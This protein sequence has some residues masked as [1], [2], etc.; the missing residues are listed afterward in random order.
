MAKKPHRTDKQPEGEPA[1]THAD[2]KTPLE[3]NV[4]R[5]WS[6]HTTMIISAITLLVVA[7]YTYYAGSQLSVMHGQLRQME[8]SN[9]PWI[10]PDDRQPDGPFHTTNITFDKD[11]NALVYWMIALKNFG[12]L[13]AQNIAANADL[14]ITQDAKPIY[15]REEWRCHGTVSKEVGSVVFPGPA[16]FE[17]RG[18]SYVH[19]SEFI[20]NPNSTDKNFVAFISG[21]VMYRDQSGRPHYTGF[22]YHLLDSGNPPKAV[23]FEPAPNMTIPA[24][25]WFLTHSIV[26]DEYENDKQ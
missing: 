19:S 17:K 16:W 7:C 21:C 5:D 10:G 9:R 13:P 3:V 24:E 2:G 26:D 1:C 8:I 18:A 25:K 12:N 20:R 22:I 6:D 23:G 11:G 4:R 15:Q 14:I